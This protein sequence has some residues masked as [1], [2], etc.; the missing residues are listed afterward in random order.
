MLSLLTVQ[1]TINTYAVHSVDNVK[2]AVI[3]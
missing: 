3:L 1:L 2:R